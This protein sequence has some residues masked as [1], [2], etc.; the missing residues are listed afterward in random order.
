[1]IVSHRHRFIFLK[2]EKTAS[3]SLA[4]VF[5]DIAGEGDRLYPAERS[6]RRELLRSGGSLA[7]YSFEAKRGG[8][9][10][11]LPALS[12]LHRHAA[13]KDV[14]AFLGP[15]LFAQYVVITSE[16]NP[17]D[18]Q[19][20]LY[21]HRMRG[22]ADLANFSRDTCSP[23]Y[24]LMHY[25]RLDNWGIYTLDGSVCADHVIRFE[26]LHDDLAIVLRTLGLDPARHPL[27]HAKQS[28]GE[29]A[30]SY[31]T[32]YTDEARER[33]AC[34]YRRELDHFGYAF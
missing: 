34:W 8:I 11:L 18:R 14:R 9:R 1:M 17:F 31:R 5:R 23:L 4:R 27:P 6:V 21:S 33:V 22:A 19:V 7:G 29:G 16:R 32:L 30:P 26:S 13:A 10:R 24:N 3:S 20:S 15:D 12:G 25:N 2:T 28:R